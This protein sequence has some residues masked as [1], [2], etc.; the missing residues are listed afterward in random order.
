MP[1]LVHRGPER[2]QV[3]RLVPGRHPDVGARERGRERVHG[4]IEPERAF[5]EAEV[6][7][8]A[9]EELLLRR[10]RKVA[11]EEGVVRG[12]ARLAHDRGQ[13][14]S[15]HVEDRLHLGRRHP[16]LVLVEEGVVGRVA[17]FH[18]LRPAECDVV[19]A[20]KRG[21]EDR[22]VVRLARLEPR[23]VRLAA[24]PCP[25]G[26]ELGRNAARLLP[27]AAGD[28][29]QARVVGVVVEL[30]LERRELV[31]QPS[32]LVGREPLVRDPGERRSHLRACG[33]ALRRHHRPLVPAGDRG[34][35]LEVVDLRQPLL[36]IRQR[37]A[38]RDATYP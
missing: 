28:A 11:F 17:L 13:L 27:V 35:L 9:V 36:Q 7:Q 37:R 18:A 25:V 1:G 10:D 22:E 30:V 34:G 16:G 31:E 6:V 24:L 15:Q 38:H 3:G 29:D 21:P 19:D 32:D 4:R 2:A 5:L 12:L 8:H 20:L 26:G 23:D 14:R 33:R